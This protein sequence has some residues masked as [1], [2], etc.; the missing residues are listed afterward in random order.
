MPDSPGNVR[1]S[2]PEQKQKRRQPSQHES[3]AG[4]GRHA[5][6]RILDRAG[7]EVVSFEVEEPC[8]LCSA[9]FSRL[10]SMTRTT[11]AIKAFVADPAWRFRD[12]WAKAVPR[13]RKGGGRAGSHGD[14][15]GANAAQDPQSRDISQQAHDSDQESPPQGPVIRSS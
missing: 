12:R 8:P 13:I 15:V 6:H 3:G 1:V 11:G 5:A 10:N 7:S 14:I 2:S 4:Q 9:T